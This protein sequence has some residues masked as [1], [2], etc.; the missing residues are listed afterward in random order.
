MKISGLQ[1]M[2]LLDYPKKIAATV[3]TSSCN[4]CYPY[5]HNASLVLNTGSAQAISEKVFLSSI[6]VKGCICRKAA[7]AAAIK[8]KKQ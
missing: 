3:F 1:K 6:P 7:E 2:T 4:F 5:C 8:L